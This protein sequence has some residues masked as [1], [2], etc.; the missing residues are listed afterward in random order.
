MTLLEFFDNVYLLERDLRASSEYQFRRSI[1]ML[2]EHAGRSLQPHELTADLLNAFLRERSE[3]LAARTVHKV[4]GDLL[5]LWRMAFDHGAHPEFPRRIRKVKV[6]RKLPRAFT[7]EQFKALVLA[8]LKLEGE[9]QL[10]NASRQG[11][12]DLFPYVGEGGV[13]PRAL[14]WNALRAFANELRERTAMV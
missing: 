6:A 8:S 12:P 11:A 9:Y 4:R 3:A 1:R 10:G 14:Y 7:Q 2:E 5:C 13:I